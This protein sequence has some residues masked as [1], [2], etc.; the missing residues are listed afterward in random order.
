M[1]IVIIIFFFAAAKGPNGTRLKNEAREPM[2]ETRSNYFGTTGAMKF[3]PVLHSFD[4]SEERSSSLYGARVTIPYRIT[5]KSDVENVL[6]SNESV[7][8]KH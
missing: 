6:K 8:A 1:V 4:R 3:P 7:R 5:G 2:N